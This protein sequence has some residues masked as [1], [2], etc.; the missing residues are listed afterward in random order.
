MVGRKATDVDYLDNDMDENFSRF[1]LTVEV[2]AHQI[3]VFGIRAK[4]FLI[5]WGGVDGIETPSV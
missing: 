5:D 1:S 2:K 4:W 3:I